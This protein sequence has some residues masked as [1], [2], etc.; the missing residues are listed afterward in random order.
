MVENAT[1]LP[2]HTDDKSGR[3]CKRHAEQCSLW[4]FMESHLLEQLLDLAN[5]NRLWE[6]RRLAILPDVV[7]VC[8][9]CR[10]ENRLSI[11]LCSVMQTQHKAETAYSNE[12]LRLTE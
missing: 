6:D 1:R 10:Q 4:H 7:R 12:T 5:R 8:K 2:F 9:V 3:K 11:A